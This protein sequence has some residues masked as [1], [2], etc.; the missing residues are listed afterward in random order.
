MRHPT[1]THRARSRVG[2]A[3]TGA[4]MALASVLLGACASPATPEAQRTN[5]AVQAL[6]ASTLDF[7]VTDLA[8]DLP[9]STTRAGFNLDGEFSTAATG[10]SVPDSFATIGDFANNHGCSL[11]TDPSCRG[12][13]DNYLPEVVDVFDRTMQT[14]FRQR[15]NQ[16]V[17]RGH[18]T[19]IVRITDIDDQIN[20]PVVKI[21]LFRA[22]PMSSSC[23]T[24]FGGTGKFKVDNASLFTA[25]DLT[26]PRWV[27]DGSIVGGKLFATRSIA[28]ATA[29]NAPL[30]VV[31]AQSLSSSFSFD[32][33]QASFYTDATTLDVNSTFTATFGG[34]VNT[35]LFSLAMENAFSGFANQIYYLMPRL[36]DLPRPSD[37][38]CDTGTPL[39]I[40]GTSMGVTLTLRPAEIMGTASSPGSGVCG[41]SW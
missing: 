8:I 39:A 21:H 31:V 41:T 11:A 18:A 28:F 1:S 32:L 12:G 24:A 29:S 4:G 14:S 2:L 15:A 9:E 13:I 27:L 34:W 38:K 22:F 17:T 5:R 19:W 35:D 33:Y 36:S 6:S 25:D 30:P 10:C 16:Y 37:L 20:D 23:A 7:V 26:T 40:G 3:F